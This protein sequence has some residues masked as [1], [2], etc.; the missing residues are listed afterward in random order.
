[1]RYILTTF[2]VKLCTYVFVFHTIKCTFEILNTP[3]NG[4]N[5][6]LCKCIIYLSISEGAVCCV[7]AAVLAG[8]SE[9]RD[10][11]REGQLGE[12]PLARVGG[13]DSDG[14]G[15]EEGGGVLG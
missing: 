3:K 10:S 9:N 8:L 4:A 15:R 1:M 13:G 12:V 5:K 11:L 2:L 6:P 14:E 7:A